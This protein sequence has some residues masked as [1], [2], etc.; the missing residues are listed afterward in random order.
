MEKNAIL[1]AVKEVSRKFRTH[2]DE[3][4]PIIVVGRFELGIDEFDDNIMQI[5]VPEEQRFT[6]KSILDYIQVRPIGHGMTFDKEG[7][8][9]YWV[10]LGFAGDQKAKFEYFAEMAGINV[11]VK[12]GRIRIRMRTKPNVRNISKKEAYGR[13][14][15]IFI[16]AVKAKAKMA[17]G[18]IDESIETSIEPMYSSYS[19]RHMPYLEIGKFLL[20]SKNGTAQITDD[21]TRTLLT[22]QFDF[23]DLAMGPYAV[24]MTKKLYVAYGSSFMGGFAIGFEDFDEDRN[25]IQVV[26]WFGQCGMMSTMDEVYKA[27]DAEKCFIYMP[28]L[29][30]PSMTR[31][32]NMLFFNVTHVTMEQYEEVFDK[33]SHGSYT[34]LKKLYEGKPLAAEKAIKFVARWSLLITGSSPFGYLRNFACFYGDLKHNGVK[35][36]DG[37]FFISSRFIMRELE[38]RGIKITHHEAFDFSNQ[39]RC[40]TIK[41]FGTVD[42]PED[43]KRTIEYLLE[44]GIAKGIRYLDLSFETALNVQ[45]NENDEYTDYILVFG[46]NDITDIDLFCDGTT[47]KCMFDVSRP[48]EYCLMDIPVEPKGHVYTSKQICNVLQVHKDSYGILLGLAKR[49][50]D[51]VLKGINDTDEGFEMDEYGNVTRTQ[52]EEDSDY[53]AGTICR[54]IPNAIMLDT[55]IRKIVFRGVINRINRICN[56]FNFSVKGGN[57]KVVP[58]YGMLFKGEFLAEDEV[59]IKGKKTTPDIVAVAFRHPLA[60][61]REHLAIKYVSLD[62]IID[63]I[64]KSDLTDERKE[65]TIRRYRNTMA[66][67]AV[68]SGGSPYIAGYFN[69]M[70]YDGDM[71]TIIE[72][73]DIVRIAMENGQS[74]NNFGKTVAGDDTFV[75]GIHSPREA[76]LYQFGLIGKNPSVNPDVGELAGYDV[77]M[78]SLLTLIKRKMIKACFV[79][80]I[81]RR[82]K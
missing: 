82:E 45:K 13:R 15:R 58:D 23:R 72:E 28:F 22:L 38:S 81:F 6:L 31:K 52:I 44:V 43:I 60:G 47:L 24:E 35:W 26:R 39:G 25:N 50:I 19:L 74:S 37:H 64:M 66:G 16:Q 68:V 57:Y 10:K 8:G 9:K 79:N 42:D 36:N 78:L 63:R 40:G 55:Q 7:N 53:A 65:T 17:S 80:E 33:C 32:A 29:Q 4:D 21:A 12:M 11:V 34:I 48:L 5:V 75:L 27:I 51:K 54:Y 3:A 14:E 41:G 18:G 77:T 49:T 30:S 70:D 2:T 61:I 56:K 76:F 69:G 71:I 20:Q 67:I 46:A 73:E 1:D 62:D 59:Y